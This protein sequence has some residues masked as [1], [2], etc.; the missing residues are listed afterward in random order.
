MDADA[1][2]NFERDAHDEIAE[3]Y[4]DLLTAVAIKIGAGRRSQN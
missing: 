4:C 1:F 2:R 3:G